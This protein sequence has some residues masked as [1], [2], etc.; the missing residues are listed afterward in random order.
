MSRPPVGE[1]IGSFCTQAGTF[2][3][4]V[5]DGLAAGTDYYYK[6]TSRNEK[7]SVSTRLFSFR[8]APEETAAISFVLTSEHGGMW[9][10]GI[11]FT[12]P[13]IRRIR[14][15]RPDFVQSLGD[16]LNDGRDPSQWNFFLFRPFHDLLCSTPFTPA[17]ATVRWE[18]TRSKT[19]RWMPTIPTAKSTSLLTAT[20][21]MTMAAPISVCW[22]ARLC[23]KR[24]A[25][26]QQIPIC[27]S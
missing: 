14:R 21:R 4:A 17:W 24:F 7:G 22:I 1:E 18:A 25:D 2:H 13:I 15:E 3:R 12:E 16:I 6:V 26:P 20:I 8:T 11:P 10:E 5:V 9:E 27:L 19:R 23:L